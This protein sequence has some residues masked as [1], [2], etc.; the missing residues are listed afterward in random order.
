MLENNIK[1]NKIAFKNKKIK[2]ILYISLQKTVIL[3]PCFNIKIN[4]KV[5]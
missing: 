1:T 4:M 5:C 2:C 3:L